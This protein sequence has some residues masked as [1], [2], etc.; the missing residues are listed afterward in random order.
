MI[1]D[2]FPSGKTSPGNN[3]WVWTETEP[4]LQADLDAGLDISCYLPASAVEIT[5]DQAREDD[6]RGC[7]DST[8]ESFGAVTYTWD[9][10]SFIVDPQGDGTEQGNLAAGTILPDA[11]AYVSLRMGVKHGTPTEATEKWDKYMVQTGAAHNTPI[12]S[13]KY[14][15]KVKMSVTKIAE[16]ATIPAA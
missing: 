11:T 12:Q 14:L 1:V 13:G 2:I 9:E 5:F 4:L 7:D 16:G 10:I 8:R 15:R 3:T 6:T